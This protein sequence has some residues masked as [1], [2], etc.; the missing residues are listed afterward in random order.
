MWSVLLQH[1]CLVTDVFFSD[2]FISFLKHTP[3]RPSVVLALHF[4]FF[5]FCCDHTHTSTQLSCHA[6]SDGYSPKGVKTFMYWKL[7]KHSTLYQVQ[8]ALPF[9]IIEALDSKRV[10]NRKSNYVIHWIGQHCNFHL[11]RMLN[12]IVFVL[13]FS[14]TRS[15]SHW[16][17]CN[18]LSIFHILRQEKWIIILFYWSKFRDQKKN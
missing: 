9:C 4:N 14:F 5:S 13:N 15:N 7:H 1:L 11:S 8:N 3:N 12:K 2:Y 6:A 16:S 17:N 18:I 10:M